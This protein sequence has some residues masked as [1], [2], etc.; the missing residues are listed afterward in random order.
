LSCSCPNASMSSTI[1]D[2]VA[3]PYEFV[4]CAPH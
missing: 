3:L 4:P 2:A 1:P